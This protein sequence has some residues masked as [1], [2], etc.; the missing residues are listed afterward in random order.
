MDAIISALAVVGGLVVLLLIV[1]TIFHLI[2]GTR[3]HFTPNTLPLTTKFGS[4]AIVTGS[5]DGIGR[6]YAFEL[7]KRGLNIVL[8]SRSEEK[9]N[10]TAEELQKQFLIQ[11]KTIAVDFSEGRKIF[12]KLQEALD[13]L[14]IGI[15]VN[16]VGKQYEYPMFLTEVPEKELWDII[17]IN[18]GATTLMTHLILPGMLKRGKGAIVNVSSGSELQPLPLM[19]VYA[20]TKTY[21]KSFSTALR[22]EYESQGITV[23]H[24]APLFVST[25]MNDFSKRLRQSSIMVPDAAAYAAGAVNTLGRLHNSA[26][27]W[28]HGVQSF[29][30]ELSPLAMRTYIGWSLN[31]IF[32]KDYF[33]K[34]KD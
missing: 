8:I 20:A 34:L 27:F 30:V 21:I 19:T 1:M 33:E 3:A 15:L 4:W 28:S 2:R 10:H 31:T 29:F 24:L 9:L 26:G 25:K 7:A 11:T 13:N 18:V 12:K 32:R 23:Q 17:N 14:E 5:T 16:N 22:C 6:A